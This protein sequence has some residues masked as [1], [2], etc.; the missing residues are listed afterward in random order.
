MISAER[1][2]ILS[3][4]HRGA[5]DTTE[6]VLLEVIIVAACRHKV[7]RFTRSFQASLASC[8]CSKLAFS[9]VASILQWPSD[10]Q[11]SRICLS[12]FI[13]RAKPHAIVAWWRALAISL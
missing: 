12:C 13:C 6:K 5:L 4:A 8:R 1:A 11:G 7:S 2:E 9:R 3:G 10:I